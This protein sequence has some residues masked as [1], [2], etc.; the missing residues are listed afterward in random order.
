MILSTLKQ[1]STQRRRRIFFY[2]PGCRYSY[3]KKLDVFLVLAT[4][5]EGVSRFS[6]TVFLRTLNQPIRV[7]CVTFLVVQEYTTDIFFSIPVCWIVSYL[8]WTFNTSNKTFNVS[9]TAVLPI[10]RNFI[11]NLCHNFQIV[12]MLFCFITV[13]LLLKKAC[14]TIPK[15]W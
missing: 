4:T 14:I 1:I 10:Y 12:I 2:V 3:S 11:Q 13:Y 5:Y 6:I 15:S 8:N 9:Y 7:Y